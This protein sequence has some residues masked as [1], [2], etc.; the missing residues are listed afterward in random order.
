M[1]IRRF[2]SIGVAS[3]VA[4]A[5]AGC[6]EQRD[7]INRVQANALD[8]GFF[9]GALDTPDDD[10]TFFTR[11]FVVDASQSQDM[12][13]ISQA[14][15]LE[16]IRWHITENTL[17]ARRAYSVTDG[18]NKGSSAEEPGDI[19]AAFPIDGHFDIRNTYNP[20]TGEELNVIDENTSDRPWQER[21]FFRVDWSENLITSPAWTTMFFG[22]IF[23]DIKLTPVSYY[24][25]D[26]ESDNAPHFDADD[27]YFD[28]TSHLLLEPESI[29]LGWAQV[30]TCFLMG[31]FTGSAIY[32]C[33]PQEAV[34]R[35]SYWRVD[36]ADPDDDFEPFENTDAPLDIFGN[37]GG[38]GDG[39]SLGIV[40]PPRET[41]DPGYGFTDAGL[42]RYMNKHNL[43][44]KSHQTTEK[45]CRT[46]SE[47]ESLTRR[48]GSLCLDS[49]HCSLPCEYEARGD[50][51]SGGNGT[52]DQ[53]E[54]SDTGYDGAQ[55][56]QCSPRNRCT[57]PYRDRQVKPVAYYVNQDMPDALQDEVRNGKLARGP[58]EDL[59]YTWNQALQL[60]VARAREVECR[61]TGGKRDTCHAMFFEV[62][63]G[64][65]KI[66]MMSH[67]GWGVETPSDSTDVLVTCHNPVRDYDPEFCGEQGTYSRDGDLRKNFVIYW[68]YATQA[69]YG[70]IGNWRGDPLTGQILGAAATTIGPSTT[71]SAARV[72]DVALV[73]IGE[74]DLTDITDGVS[75]YRFQKILREGRKPQALTKEEIARRLNAVNHDHLNQHARFDLRGL[76]VQ[77]PAL[78]VAE[79]K[80]QLL[81][82][83]ALST[84]Q[85]LKFQ[86]AAQPLLGSTFEARMIDSNWLVDAAGL[87]PDTPLNQSVLDLV[88]P[89]RGY[90]ESHLSRLDNQLFARM[91]RRGVCFLENGAPV[92]SPELYG[93]GPFY[94]EKYPS[95][96]GEELSDQIYEDVWREIYKGIQLHE[97]GHSLGLLHNFTSS[98]DSQNYVPQYWQL[99]SH[100]GRSTADCEG[101]PRAGDT[102]GDSSDTCMGPRYLDPETNDEL[103]MGNEPRPGIKYF[104]HTSTMEYQSARFFETVGLGQYDVMAMGALYGRVLQTYDE[105]LIPQSQQTEYERFN[106]TQLSESLSLNSGAGRHYTALARDLQLFDASRCRDATDGEVRRAEWRIVHGKVCAPPPKDYGHWDDFSNSTSTIAA[107]KQ[108]IDEALAVPAA[109]NVRW[110]YRFGG[111]MMNAYLH[112]NPFDSGADPYEV[113]RETIEKNEYNYPFT[114]FR[115][116]RRGWARWTLPSYTARMF[117]ERLRSYHW[118]ISFT[119]AFYNEITNAEPRF[120]DFVT[121]VR[122]DDNELRPYLVAQSEMFEAIV[123]NYMIPE[124]GSYAAEVNADLG[125]FDFPAIGDNSQRF[126][127]DASVGRFLAPSF[128]SSSGAG[129]SW[130]YQDYVNRAGYTVE[131]TL[132]SRALTDGR[133]VFFSVGRDIYLDDRNININ[134]RSDFPNGVDRLLGGVLAEDW[135]T[136]APFILESENP[137][138]HSRDLISASPEALPSGAK[139][140]FPNLGYNQHIV[141]MI[142]AQLFS[143]L[144]G[145]LTLSTKMRMWLDGSVSAE[146]DIPEAEQARF[147]DPDSGFTYIARRYGPETLYS[148]EV[149][150]GIA[151]RMI[152]RANRLLLSVYQTEVGEDGD[153]LADEFGRPTLLRDETG[154]LVPTDD[155]SAPAKFRSYVGLLDAN[156][157]LSTL[158]GHGPNNW[159]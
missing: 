117:Y 76:E 3:T 103:G 151:S 82:D 46:H 149:D 73:G 152:E 19:I 150:R 67:G 51:D 72:R 118:G 96:S 30:P 137:E 93:V 52:D 59:L 49:G 111:D 116:D 6:A 129:G 74:L 40:T 7:P 130:L 48:S 35:T 69:P 110:P 50:T 132:A 63:G 29:D 26:P 113:T 86:A 125:V 154:A 106:N 37:P 139:Q 90:D 54:N 78:S 134:F 88:S 114:Y 28:I 27:G 14:S 112:V 107:P 140:I 142:Y 97:L 57:I 5:A 89:L 94:Q 25:S 53:C 17:F 147:T 45:T 119:N 102:T 4:L 15:G 20:S 55:G 68:P 104:G 156:V 43:W 61:R 22:Q 31:L 83:A 60:A 56:S 144:N 148:R 138:L 77:N 146:I 13:G 120:S 1:T 79:L 141:T 58:T 64:R 87:S 127:L 100:D 62:D 115:R 75:A 42:R 23:G 85:L 108:R 155:D 2:L 11:S 95:L 16:R 136:V 84:D 71:I 105:R 36:K 21:R 98:Y 153:I 38:I 66:Q 33:D 99:R 81:P 41:W 18:D 126:S 109:G 122:N 135:P 32:S 12:V 65:D 143:R 121:S 8:K 157:Q 131:K 70:G 9:V 34:V 47:C 159:F 145:D 158:I 39:I 80:A 101:E 124:P 128:D 44:K 123:D 133:A 10:P 92:G 24:E 91:G